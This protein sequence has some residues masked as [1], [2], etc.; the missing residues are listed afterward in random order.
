MEEVKMTLR[1]GGIRIFGSAPFEI[2]DM[3]GITFC[4][5]ARARFH[6][7]RNVVEAAPTG[8]HLR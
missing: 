3:D 2:Q 8:N 1:T 7:G 6:C 4:M 5:P